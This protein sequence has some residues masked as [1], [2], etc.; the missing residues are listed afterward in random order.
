MY[1]RDKNSGTDDDLVKIQPDLFVK[2]SD[3]KLMIN[4]LDN[5]AVKTRTA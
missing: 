1:I 5:N 2:M 4:V 3:G